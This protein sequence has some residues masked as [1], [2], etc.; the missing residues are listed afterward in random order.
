MGGRTV[1]KRRDAGRRGVRRADARRPGKLVYFFGG[2]HADGRQDMR[3]L[4]GGKGANLAEMAGLRLPVP[5][6]FT[7][8]T[9]VCHYFTQHNGTYPAGLRASVDHHLAGIEQQVDRRFGHPTRPLLV[10]V[11]SGARASMPGMMDTVLNLGLNN[12]TVQALIRESGNPRFAYDCYR[13]FIQ[14]FGDVVLGL[15]PESKTGPDPFEELIEQKKHIRGVA[16]DTELNADDLRELAEGFKLLIKERL[17]LDFPDAPVEQLW[18]AIGA[19]FRSWDNPRAITYRKINRIPDDWGTAVNVQAMVF[20]NLGDDCATGVAFTRN[21]ATGEKG[22]YGEFLANA[23]GE[24]V[25]AGIRTPQQITRAASRG[26]ASESGISEAERR[27]RYPSLEESMPHRYRQLQRIARQLERH[28]RDMQDLEFTIE[29]GRLWMLQT[30]SGKRTA[31]A[32]VKTAVDMVKERLIDRRTGVLRVQPAQLDQLL[33]P[34]LDRLAKRDV[35][36]RGLPASSGAASGEVVFSADDAVAE[37]TAGKRVILVRIETSPEDI[38]GMNVA[39]G[40][41]TARGGMTS[42]AAVVARGMGKCCVAGCGGLDID[43]SA[44][45]L[46]VMNR[47]IRRGD[48][49]T[50][51]GSSGEVFAGTVPTIT[52]ELGADFVTFMRW[53]DTFRRLKVRANADTPQDARVARDFG[54]EGIGLCRTEHMFFEGDRIDAIREMILATDRTGRERALDKL[55]PMQKS[56]FLGILRTMAGLPVTI[57][58]LDPP[59][60]E[61]L[62]PSNKELAALA[63]KLGVSEEE[64]RKTPR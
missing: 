48:A 5:P 26:R 55:L 60:H 32:A 21:P 34:Q 52:P 41:L 23:Q 36:C 42:H 53:A 30:R 31:A 27:R 14:M 51:D 62:P 17:N 63:D 29:R 3:N 12:V 9:D 38:E 35:L 44:D 24:D 28:Y 37:A 11:R 2:G 4:L 1:A 59:L 25:V 10:S 8:T 43:Y 50:L 18:Q 22:I 15:K 39:Q 57:R 54:A 33:H 46:R 7:I 56:D 58:L 61:F 40:I 64:L 20:G 16:L 6:G 13:R 49:I 45:V 19:V 47:E